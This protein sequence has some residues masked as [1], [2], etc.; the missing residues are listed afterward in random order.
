MLAFVSHSKIPLRLSVISGCAVGLT[1]IVVGAYF[2]VRKMISW[3]SFQLGV[4]PMLVGM[5]F[6][7]G[8][9]LIFLGI[10][11]EYVSVILQYVRKRP[12]VVEEER[13]NFD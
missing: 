3:D 2:V 7:G 11:G 5:F 6:L 8:V 13:V 1:S 12:V 9:Q 4:A 10:I